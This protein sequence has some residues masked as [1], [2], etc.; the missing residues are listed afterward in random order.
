MKAKIVSLLL[1]AAGSA[2]G[3]VSLQF[4][5]TVNSLA[6]FANGAGAGG[7]NL[8]WGVVIDAGGNGFSSTYEPGL[9]Y[10][11]GTLQTLVGTDDVFWIQGSMN[12][13]NATQVANNQADGQVA[14]DNRVTSANSIPFGINGVST[15]D[16]FRVIWFDKTAV[17]G[18][19]INGDKFGV[20]SNANFQI[21]GDG[22]TVPLSS[23]FAGAEPLKPMTGTFGVIPE[24]S[25]ALLGLLGVLGLV[26]RRR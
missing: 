1:L 11:T 17:G 9:G 12:I 15:G 7:S 21:P 3:T 5:T 10:S 8:L 13:F 23:F 22:A 16:V 24:P 6:N 20:F 25:T 19:A 2:F 4:S 26:R 18:A 14:G